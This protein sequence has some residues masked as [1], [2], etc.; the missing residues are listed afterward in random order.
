MNIYIFRLYRHYF[1]FPKDYPTR[2]SWSSIGYY[3]NN[4]L[5]QYE[6]FIN[7]GRTTPENYTIAQNGMNMS[8]INNI[9]V[10]NYTM[11]FIFL[12]T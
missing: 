1:R 4:F 7:V 3:S 12:N 5:L 10:S 6:Y 2:I 8:K 11:Y 9:N